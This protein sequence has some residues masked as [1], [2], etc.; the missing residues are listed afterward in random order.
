MVPCPTPVSSFGSIYLL[1]NQGS[2][3]ITWYLRPG[4]AIEWYEQRPQYSSC[5]KVANSWPQA[6]TVHSDSISQ[7]Y[8]FRSN[9]YV[10]CEQ[11]L[12]RLS[13]E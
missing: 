3:V 12:E 5:H 9:D 2:E 1:R 7:H 13:M 8:F 6:A 11:F 10:L 4:V